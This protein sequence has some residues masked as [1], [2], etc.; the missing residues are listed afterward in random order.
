MHRERC[1]ARPRA[2]HR[3]TWLFAEDTHHNEDDYTGGNSAALKWKIRS[4]VGRRFYLQLNCSMYP[5]NSLSAQSGQSPCVK[6]ASE[7]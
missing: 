6:S 3:R 7:C 2:S 1:N 4:P 5:W